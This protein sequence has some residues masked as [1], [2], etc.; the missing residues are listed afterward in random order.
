ML[1]YETIKKYY[2]NRYWSVK[3]VRTA[4]LKGYITKAQYE[5]IVGEPYPTIQE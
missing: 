1:D 4:V 3:M 5:E 2:N